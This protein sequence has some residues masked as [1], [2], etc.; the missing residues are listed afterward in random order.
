MNIQLL[1]SGMTLGPPVRPNLLFSPDDDPDLFT[2]R[3][4]VRSM[5][6]T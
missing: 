4:Q 2:V 1:K 5:S 3:V 6:R